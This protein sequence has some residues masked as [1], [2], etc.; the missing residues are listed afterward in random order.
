MIE[1]SKP[2][3][4]RDSTT[5]K[6]SFIFWCNVCSIT[7]LLANAIYALGLTMVVSPNIPKLIVTPHVVGYVKIII[8]NKLFSA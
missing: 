4:N 3:L 2:W 5:W 6:P 1:S 7:L 8:Y